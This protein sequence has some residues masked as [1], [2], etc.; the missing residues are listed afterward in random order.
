[1][2][3]KDI[4]VGGFYAVSLNQG[5][6]ADRPGGYYLK[7]ARVVGIEAVPSREKSYSEKSPPLDGLTVRLDGD[8]EV[9][10]VSTRKVICGWS[11][12]EAALASDEQAEALRAEQDRA[13]IADNQV[14]EARLQ[15]ILGDAM[16]H[17]RRNYG[18]SG[19]AGGIVMTT[20]TLLDV[21]EAAFAAGRRQG[22]AE[23]R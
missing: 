4:E 21:V 20:T 19:A 5:R 13:A 8:I 11:D 22:E 9:C 14:V 16:P 18:V 17:I 23:S 3:R 1:M 2:Q 12:H 6:W 15:E 10:R 7:R